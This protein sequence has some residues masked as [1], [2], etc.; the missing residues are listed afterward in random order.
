MALIIEDGSGVANANS[1]ISAASAGTYLN[2]RSATWTSASTASQE[3]A[4]FI[5]GQYLNSLN[6]KGRKTD[7]DN[8]MVWP[9]IDVYDCDN[10]LVGYATVP[11][12]IKYAQVEAAVFYM[13]GYDLFSVIK[14]G[15]KLKRK[16]IDVIEK[17]WFGSAYSTK[18]TITGAT[19]FGII[20]GLLKCYTKSRGTITRG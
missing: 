3:Q 2:G 14:R 6:W 18:G 9:R 16:K 13:D 7:Q 10:Y 11:N 12:N 15:D 5:A 8:T 4:L 1:F 20:D 19:Y 17:E